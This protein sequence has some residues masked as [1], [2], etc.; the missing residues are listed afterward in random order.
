MRVPSIDEVRQ[1]VHDHYVVEELLGQGGMGAVY[2]ARHKS[3]DSAVAIKV[4]PVPA[5]V[6][7]DELARFRREAMIAAGLQHPNIVPVYEFDIR[8][9]LAFLVMPLI[10]GVALDRRIQNEGPMGW[11]AT[12]ELLGQIGGALE[13]AHERGVVHRDVKPANILWEPATGRWLVT[14]FGI[15]RRIREDGTVLT[16]SGVIVGTPAYMAP[17]Q[18]AGSEVD[19]R[20]DIYGLGAVA[21]EALTGARPEPMSDAPRAADQLKQACPDLSHGQVS[22]LTAALSLDRAER[23]ASVREWLE[24][25]DAVESHRGVRT[26]LLVVT[27][28]G[29]VL[30]AVVWRQ[31]SAPAAT[32]VPLTAVIPLAVA[33][34]PGLDTTLGRRLAEAFTEQLR[35]LP[36]QRVA[37]VSSV[38][39]AVRGH[40]GGLPA[41]LDTVAT[42]VA[43]QFGATRVLTG[44]LR[45][46]D[47]D[48]VRVAVQLRS[49]T[50]E[51]LRADSAVA[52][53]DSLAGLVQGLVIALFAE[54]LA[55][56][57]TG[58]SPVLPQGARAVRAYLAAR[59]RFRA[60]A[61]QEA[62]ELYEEVI[63]ADSTFTPAYFE[64]TLAE[65]LRVQPTRANRA[66]R[67]ALD[68]TRRYRDRLDPAT[69]DLL[70]GYE[71]L[72]AEGDLEGA[73]EQ[74]RDL[75]QRYEN[76]PDA[77]F[78][79][80]YLEFHFGPLFGVEPASARFALERASALAP[81]FAAPRGLLGWIAVANDE[82][83]AAEHLRSYLAIDSASV[84]AELVRMVDS[85]RFR[86]GRAALQ[87]VASLDERPVP[88]LELIALAGASLTLKASERDVAAD[89][90]RALRARATTAA[91]RAIA[92][93]LE[94]AW[95]LGG[96]RLGSAGALLEEGR[97]RN[98]PREELDA[99][100][101]L[102]A[103]TG[104]GPALD[105]T[106][107][108]AAATRL[109]AATGD[110]TAQWLAARRWRGRDAGTAARSRR[111]L[112]ALARA[113]DGSALLARSLLADLDAL[114]RLA[115]GDTAG[116]EERWARA[117]RRYQI[118][119]VPFGLVASLWPLEL[120]RARVATARG[121]HDAVALLTDRFRHAVGFMD[122]VARL[123]ALP[124]GVAALQA[125]N[126]ALRAR[127][128][129]QRL[130]TLWRDADGAGPALRDSLRARVPGL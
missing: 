119:E 92:F 128:L 72:V 77:W 95:L 48:R 46:A 76:A 43:A 114:D 26:A 24:R 97:R 69:R 104:V 74:F 14:D 32:S 57:Q 60:G 50:G 15:A 126:D 79:L 130:L 110:P 61:Y 100:T 36:D 11:A 86:G 45:A 75:V 33:A 55:R 18:A 22:A 42:F 12:R 123:E 103:V 17:E 35:W 90:V 54:G 87:V 94:M 85:I 58:W 30:A 16:V 118:E 125:R 91:D 65:I 44:R 2:R 96:A 82:P 7:A 52:P 102:L 83:D 25:V 38:E 49:G 109:A 6:G 34:E 129:A 113:S 41:D 106:S 56:E 39:Q 68:A 20:A 29:L 67:A 101:A 117:A 124:L 70:A 108:E 84:S 19:S 40:F 62:V 88:A 81:E 53:T 66:V 3:L 9:D 51:L 99:W 115:A 28:V 93:R 5:S 27:L 122:Q 59:P 127:E 105:D 63:A 23:P 120:E 121:D 64:R 116:A 10:E 47:G 78:I 98:V 1:A 112:Q 13:F 37:T 31:R 4:L 8:D 71:T 89:A 111:G 107:V 21:F 80:G 73:H